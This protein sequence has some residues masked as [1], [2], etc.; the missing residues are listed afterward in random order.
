MH[1][2]ANPATHAILIKPIKFNIAE[3]HGQAWRFSSSKWLLYIRST[4]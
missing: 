3:A 4:A 2:L 1:V